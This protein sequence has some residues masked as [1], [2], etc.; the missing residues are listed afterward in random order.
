MLEQKNLTTVKAVK[1]R[2]MDIIDEK[3]T[4]KRKESNNKY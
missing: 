1:D 4:L 2:T 3:K